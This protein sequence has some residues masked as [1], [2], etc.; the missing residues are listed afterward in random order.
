MVTEP[1]QKP[2][3]SDAKERSDRYLRIG[4]GCAIFI[5]AAIIFLVIWAS[6]IDLSP[7]LSQAARMVVWIISG[8]VL[9]SSILKV[10]LI[11]KGKYFRS[12][13]NFPS[14]L[15]ILP[16]VVGLACLAAGWWVT[17]A[18]IFCAIIF[19][20]LAMRWARRKTAI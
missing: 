4:T 3:L 15:S 12:E 6:W 5:W 18:I 1:P 9:L 17:G 10:V 2:T 13:E 20:R 11:L 19:G 14:A 7:W 8:F 16:F